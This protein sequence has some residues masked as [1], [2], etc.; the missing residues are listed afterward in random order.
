M[1]DAP[2]RIGLVSDGMG[3]WA[4]WNREDWPFADALPY[5]R[6]DLFDAQARQIE[7]LE[8]ALRMLFTDE[9]MQHVRISPAVIDSARAALSKGT[10]G[11]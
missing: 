7:K 9:D 8:G 3:R 2:E 1:S 6:A 4:L 5:V 11:E 10:E